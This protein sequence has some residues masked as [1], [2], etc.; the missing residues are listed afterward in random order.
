MT[1]TLTKDLKVI[2]WNAQSLFPKS[3]EIIDFFET[4]V[5]DVICINETWL[6]DSHRLFFPSYKLYR[7]DRQAGSG[8][9]VAMAVN[10]KIKHSQLPSFGTR[11]VESVAVSID[12][13]TGPITFVSVYF[14]GTDLSSSS[15]ADF[16]SDI[17]ILTSIR[18]SYFL[19]GDLNAKHRLWNKRQLSW[20]YCF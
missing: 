16:K 14:P 5:Y 6:N 19:C 12:I 18:N 2:S 10:R 13:P 4:N 17:K 9:G 1:N 7:V 15:M 11:S 8:G 20:Q 3:H